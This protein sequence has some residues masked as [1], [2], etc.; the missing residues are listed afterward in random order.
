MYIL[1]NIKRHVS[2]NHGHHQV[3][4]YLLMFRYVNE[5]RCGDLNINRS[6]NFKILRGN[7]IN[8][9]RPSTSINNALKN[10]DWCWHLHIIAH[11][12]SGTLRDTVKPDDGHDWPKHV[13]WYWLEYTFFIPTS[14]VI[15][16]P[17]TYKFLLEKRGWHLKILTWIIPWVG[18]FWRQCLA[19]IW[20]SGISCVEY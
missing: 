17:S 18:W 14:C 16:Y 19:K 20:T 9:T 12:H 15:D 6:T 4:P 13:V 8:V 11:L 1:V 7:Y 2:A 3:W 10:R 5:L